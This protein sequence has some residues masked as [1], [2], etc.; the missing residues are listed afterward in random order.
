[1]F[2]DCGRCEDDAV[3]KKPNSNM[4]SFVSKQSP[5]SNNIS[6]SKVPLSNTILSASN[7]PSQ[8][9]NSPVHTLLRH[10][11]STNQLLTSGVHPSLDVT[12]NSQPPS[13]TQNPLPSPPST[14]NNSPPPQNNSPP[15]QNNLPSPQNKSSPSPQNNL[16]SPT[17]DLL[18]PLHHSKSHH[19]S[20]MKDVDALLEEYSQDTIK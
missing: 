12:Q 2:D 10:Q 13:A 5:Q 8:S 19:I 14:Q 4:Q 3:V 1:M 16:P 7:S 17:Q 20:S 15:P 9:L 6:P 18:R 11:N